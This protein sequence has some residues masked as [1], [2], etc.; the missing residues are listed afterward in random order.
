MMPFLDPVTVT[1][2]GD[3]IQSKAAEVTMAGK[4]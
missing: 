2:E 1:P 3:A 4:R